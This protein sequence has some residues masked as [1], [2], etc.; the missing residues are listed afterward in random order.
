MAHSRCQQVML[1]G[2]QGC[3]QRTAV[4]L[5]VGF[6]AGCLGFLTAWWLG[7]KSQHPSRTRQ[8]I[9]FPLCPSPGRHIAPL[10]VESKPCP[11]SKAENVDPY[12]LMGA[13]STSQS[14]WDG[15]SCCSHWGNDTMCQEN[16]LQNSAK[17]E[18]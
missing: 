1:A 18:L 5:Q 11:D 4:I 9:D 3:R 14:S 15:R 16:S 8:K 2:S 13:V 17:N 7:S 6:S 10:P 12:L